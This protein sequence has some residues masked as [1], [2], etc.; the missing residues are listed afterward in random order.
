MIQISFTLSFTADTLRLKHLGKPRTDDG[1]LKGE[2]PLA[3]VAHYKEAADTLHL[4]HLGKPWP[5]R[6]VFPKG[7]LTKVS[8]F[9]ILG[10]SS[11]LVH[12]HTPHAFAPNLI[13]F[14]YMTPGRPKF[15]RQFLSF[16]PQN[17]I[18]LGG[19]IDQKREKN[20]LDGKNPRSY[21]D[22]CFDF[23][24]GRIF[25]LRREIPGLGQRNPGDLV[26]VPFPHKPSK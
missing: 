3:V 6:T 23:F 25:D 20:Q 13:T 1:L 4:K 11:S 16:L 18:D 8:A 17:F 7:P 2:S 10:S 24:F 22:R 14:C 19:K 15:L 12:S 5:V 9:T 26:G 21:F